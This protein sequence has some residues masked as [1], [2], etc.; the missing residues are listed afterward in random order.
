MFTRANWYYIWNSRK[1]IRL[2]GLFTWIGITIAAIILGVSDGIQG[3][4]EINQLLPKSTA[5]SQDT[6]T[7]NNSN[8]KKTVWF[9]I[10]II[11]F[12]SIIGSVINFLNDTR[13]QRIS[14][15]ISTKYLHPRLLKELENLYNTIASNYTPKG[16]FR[17][18]IAMP[19]AKKIFRWHYKV[20]FGHRSYINDENISI[21]V[22]EGELGYLIHNLKHLQSQRYV[23]QVL[24]LNPTFPLGYN[25]I[26]HPN[27]SLINQIFPVNNVAVMGLFDKS[28]LCGVLVVTTSDENN[29]KLLQNQNFKNTLIA[30]IQLNEELITTIWQTTEG[31]N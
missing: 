27:S 25:Q 24:E 21:S 18:Y 14:S 17:V 13:D 6:S 5:L 26:S 22:S 20:C 23:P 11:V 15:Q 1:K 31:R 19:Y 2:G 7:D 8:S 29:I 16:D 28:L 4:N 3:L 9:V 12:P 30:F 10:G